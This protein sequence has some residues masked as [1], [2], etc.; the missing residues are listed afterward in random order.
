MGMNFV[1]TGHKY[2]FVIGGITSLVTVPFMLEWTVKWHLT[3]THEGRKY[4]LLGPLPWTS[5]DELIRLET[6]IPQADPKKI[7]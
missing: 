7:D 1:L 4:R 2:S 6:P 3:R 5:N